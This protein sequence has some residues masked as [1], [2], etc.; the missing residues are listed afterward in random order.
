MSSIIRAFLLGQ[1]RSPRGLSTSSTQPCLLIGS[2]YIFRHK[3][4][5]DAHQHH[6]SSRTERVIS[7]ARVQHQSSQPSSI[8]SSPRVP[9]SPLTEMNSPMSDMNGKRHVVQHD[10]ASIRDA[11]HV[12]K[13]EHVS[14]VDVCV[15]P[16]LRLVGLVFWAGADGLGN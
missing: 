12:A 6:L 11:L 3:Q 16:W 10:W 4:L 2:S 8:A 15:S 13:N 9:L 7:R 5:V 14:S 1:F